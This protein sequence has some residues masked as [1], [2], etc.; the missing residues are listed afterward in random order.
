MSEGDGSKVEMHL[1]LRGPVFE[2]F[3]SG[4]DFNLEF[5]IYA[6]KS[7]LELECCGTITFL[8][9][10]VRSACVIYLFFDLSSLRS[11]P[12]LHQIFLLIRNA[13]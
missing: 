3:L 6:S 11:T 9:C 10:F 4:M 2:N 1:E 8:N 7:S 13:Y 5:H 12:L